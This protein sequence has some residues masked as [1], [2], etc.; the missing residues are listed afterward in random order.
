MLYNIPMR[1]EHHEPT[2]P[3][4]SHI[5]EFASR[6][7]EAEFWD[8]HDFTDYLDELEP[9]KIRKEWLCQNRDRQAS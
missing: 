8:I 5:P 2:K 4:K 9:V 3:H 1:D 7:E 6:E